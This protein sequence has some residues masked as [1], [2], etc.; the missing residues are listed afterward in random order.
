MPTIAPVPIPAGPAVPDSSNVEITFDAQWEAF[1][2]W[3]KNDLA[4]GA[5]AL[6]VNVKANADEAK[7]SADAATAQAVIAADKAAEAHADSLA[8][9]ADRLAVA[10]DKAAVQAIA[11]TAGVSSVNSTHGDIVLKSVG[12]VSLLGAGDIPINAFSAGDLLT[13][14]RAPSAPAWLPCD[15]A[16][17]LQASY[18]ALFAELGLLANGLAATVRTLPI[19]GTVAVA[20]GG[21]VFVAIGATTAASSPDGI[22][23]TARTIPA[24]P[25]GSYKAVAYGNGVFV[26][27]ENNGSKAATSPDGINWTARNMPSSS[28]WY[29]VAF[30]NGVFVSIS[31]VTGTLAATSPDGITW[32][33]RTL[34]TSTGWYDVTYGNGMFFAVSYATTAAASSPDGITWTARIMPTTTFIKVNFGGGLFVALNGSGLVATSTDGILWVTQVTLP[35]SA[36]WGSISYGAGM[37]II[38]PA[39][40]PIAFTSINGSTWT[41]WALPITNMAGAAYGTDKF[42]APS[43]ASGASGALSLLPYTYNPATQFA[44]PVIPTS[45][46]L[47]T[48]IKGT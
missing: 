22:T 44:A 6:A 8:T 23:W 25:T 39:N 43:T 7:T 26:A 37:F 11:A 45:Q 24:P 13:T 34:P 5:N 14:A 48:Y 1:N 42:A 40:S 29:S 18:A 38:M 12:S 32:T 31:N 21:G 35:V 10:T 36:T 41:S 15:G 9:E 30:G 46:T 33:A 28:Y 3:A 4:P 17:Y 27:V 19:S 47:T 20:Y 16:V 2:A